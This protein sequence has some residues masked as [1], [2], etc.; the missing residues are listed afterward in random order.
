MMRMSRLIGV[1]LTISVGVVATV[2]AQAPAQG[3]RTTPSV[4]GF[5]TRLDQPPPTA[6]TKAPVYECEI[7]IWKDGAPVTATMK[8]RAL[9]GQTSQL[10]I[11]DGTF[12][13]SFKTASDATE[14]TTKLERAAGALTEL[15]A[16]KNAADKSNNLASVISP[17][18]MQKKAVNDERLKTLL[19]AKLNEAA[20]AQ[21]LAELVAKLHPVELAELGTRLQVPNEF[22]TKPATGQPA[23]ANVGT[24]NGS[25][26]PAGTQPPDQTTGEKSDHERRLRKSSSS[27]SRS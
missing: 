11:P 14:A 20:G 27:S 18:E 23:T 12:D 26:Q 10:T 6:L 24:K 9:P 21:T 13:F 8:V 1:F 16:S 15:L 7:R 17:T 19:E 4:N 5:G 22:P 25:N 2:L 3:P